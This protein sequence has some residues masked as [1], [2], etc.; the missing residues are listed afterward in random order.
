MCFQITKKHKL[1]PTLMPFKHHK[2]KD[3]G[4]LQRNTGLIQADK[5]I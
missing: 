2:K 1:L 4:E 5:A 3:K